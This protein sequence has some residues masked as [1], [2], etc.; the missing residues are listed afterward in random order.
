[1]VNV[2]EI[3]DTMRLQDKLF[4]QMTVA[5]PNATTAY[6]A[7]GVT[8]D[9]GPITASGV[10]IADME[11]EIS[12]A[13]FA[14]GNL[15]NA[16]TITWAVMTENTD[17]TIDASSVLLGEVIQ[18]LGAG[19]VGDEGYTVRFRLP[20][21]TL[22]YVGIRAIASHDASAGADVTMDMFF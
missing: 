2:S 19:G 8:W 6:N 7:A 17:T 20:S 4:P 9:L 10:R 11:L 13:D 1:M 15:A 22:R 3:K 5:S 16:A 12:V 18:M 14:V 21:T